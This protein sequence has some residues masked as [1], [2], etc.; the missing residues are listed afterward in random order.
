M[1]N[2]HNNNKKRKIF[3]GPRRRRAIL[4]CP[5][6]CGCPVCTDVRES[7]Q[8]KQA[9]IVFASIVNVCDHLLSFFS[10]L[11]F[12]ICDAWVFARLFSLYKD[13]TA[14]ALP[15]FMFFPP[16]FYFIFLFQN[17]YPFL[18]ELQ[19]R[20]KWVL[21]RDNHHP[22]LFFRMITAVHRNQLVEVG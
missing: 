14:S 20:L 4:L 16:T 8:R 22:F 10:S 6:R 11:R 9:R 17:G 1:T 12:F 19:W 2:T 15:G 3:A 18:S 21:R 7:D 13:K 5:V